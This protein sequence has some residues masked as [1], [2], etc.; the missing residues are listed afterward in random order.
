MNVQKQIK[1][2]SVYAIFFDE[3]AL[4]RTINSLKSQ[5]FRKSDIS[6]LMDNKSPEGATA[7]ATS[8][9]VAGGILG[10]LVGLGTLTIPGLGPF[11]AAGPIMSAIAGVG[12][13]GT[14]GG[15][16]GGLIGL[17]IPEDQATIYESNLKEGGI[18]ISIQF[19]NDVW[20]SRAKEILNE[21]GANNITST[22][23]ETIDDDTNYMTS[24]NKEEDFNY[25]EI[26]SID[27]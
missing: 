22:P 13:G 23:V 26:Y 17:G 21:N 27:H 4:N 16:T 1:E 5:N 15:L 25:K 24:P 20:E 8:G 9:A 18:L 6:I 19:E 7:G 3:L 12:I 11:L 2:K 10:W 14:I